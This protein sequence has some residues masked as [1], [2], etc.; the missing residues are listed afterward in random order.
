M[1]LNRWFGIIAS[2]VLLLSVIYP[3]N[4]FAKEK[5]TLQ[6]ESIYDLLVDR[7][8][9]GDYKNDID[10]DPKTPSMFSGGDFA[11]IIDKLE[12]ISEMGFTMISIGSVF[13]SETYDGHTVL[14]YGKI[15]PHFGTEEDLAK[16]IETF[17]GENIGV[18]ADFPLNGVSEQHVWI[19]E[20]H[21]PTSQANGKTVEWDQTD[22]NVRAMVKEA[23]LDFVMAYDWNGI[24][25]TDLGDFDTDY[26]DEVIGAIKDEKPHLY[27]LTTEE[28]SA[29]F[30]SMPN[31]EKGKALQQTYVEFDPDSSG[32]SLFSDKVETDLIQF[33]DLTSQRFTDQ[34]VEKRMFPPARWKLALTA[35]FTL[36]GVPVTTYETELAVSGKEAP[37]I[38]PIVNFKADTELY[39]FITDL[40][41]LRNESEA[42]RNGDFEMMHNENGFTVFKRS[43]DEETWIIALNNTSKVANLP[44]SKEVLGDHKRLRGVLSGDSIPKT[45]DENYNVVLERESGD[46][47]IVEEDR[48]FNTPYLIASILV[49]V[50]FLGFLY[51]V[52]RK[53]RQKAKE[54]A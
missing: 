49:Y 39:D 26:L 10:V 51:V 5:R 13:S 18:M 27:V 12:Y 15:E 14:D 48:G 3:L 17:H 41:Y 9:N 29:Q 33:D 40:N 22:A 54:N 24:R 7:F 23:I 47:F 28:T 6:D 11:G 52:W 43:S 45:K 50:L 2:A 25:L 32:L 16:M 44:I 21:L 37:A 53:G 1:K 8:N 36:P 34:M 38:H 35:L 20:D 4:G 42:L 46:I 19:K 30:D 31:V